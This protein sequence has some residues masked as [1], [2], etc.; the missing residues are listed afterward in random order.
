MYG[1]VRGGGGSS[2]CLLDQGSRSDLCLLRAQDSIETI[3]LRA[4]R[5]LVVSRGRIYLMSRVDLSTSGIAQ[6]LEFA[7]KAK[8]PKAHRPLEGGWFIGY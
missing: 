3:R 5:R 7:L 1:S 4:S 2:P 6:S 8:Q